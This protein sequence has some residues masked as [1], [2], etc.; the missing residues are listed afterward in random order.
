MLREQRRI[1]GA[2]VEEE[3]EVLESIVRMTPSKFQNPGPSGCFVLKLID[4]VLGGKTLRR[5]EE[6]EEE[7]EGRSKTRDPCPRAG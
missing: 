1:E 2:I 7:E 3:E 5:E 6:E 4:G